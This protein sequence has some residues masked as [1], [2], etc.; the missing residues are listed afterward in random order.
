MNKPN[1]TIHALLARELT[2]DEIQRVSGA[3]ELVQTTT[4]PT[5][6]DTS[7]GWWDSRNHGVPG[8]AD[9]DGSWDGD[10]VEE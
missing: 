4:E 8:G 6:G 2:P 1:R 7:G 10:Q 5:Y 9:D 3:G